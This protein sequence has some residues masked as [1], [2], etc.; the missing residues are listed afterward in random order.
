MGQSFQYPN[1]LVGTDPA[2]LSKWGTWKAKLSLVDD[3]YIKVAWDGLSYGTDLGAFPQYV[4]KIPAGD[5]EVSFDAYADKDIALD[6]CY[7]MRHNRINLRLGL[8]I[9]I[10]T[11]PKT[12]SA[13]FNVGEDQADSSFMVGTT[14]ADRTPFYVRHL[15]LAAGGGR[16]CLG[17]GCWGGVAVDE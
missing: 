14:D 11:V 9:Q 12:Y 15:M 6:Y 16:S 3:G 13:K 10:T 2:D 8:H 5:Y 1:L 7:I 17:A 4:D